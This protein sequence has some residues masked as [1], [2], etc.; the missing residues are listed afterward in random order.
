MSE[1]LG[2]ELLKDLITDGVA[3]LKKYSD[4]KNDD[5]KIS[6]VEVIGMLPKIGAF[7]KD[8]LKAKELL[9]EAKNLDSDEGRQ[10]LD[11]VVSLGV[12]GDK[13]QIVMVNLLEI[14]EI[15]VA[16]WNNNVIPIIKVFKK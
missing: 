16:V 14:I 9:A 2:I 1:E 13:A 4:A 11:H 6:K 5:G 7:A 10:L 15:E 3:V 8:F 12:V